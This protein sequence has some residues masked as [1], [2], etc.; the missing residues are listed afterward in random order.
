[1]QQVTLE[2]KLNKKRRLYAI[3]WGLPALLVFLLA[4]NFLPV[5]PIK[6]KGFFKNDRP[7]VIAH[8]GGELLAPS[9]TIAAFTSAATMG[10]DALETDLHIT[11][12]GYL[13]AIHDP[14]VDRTT[15][16]H[17]K[18][19]DMT[20]EEIQKL[21]AGY[22]FKDLDGQYSYR[23]KGVYIPTAEEMFQT[24]GNMRIEME[25]KD[26]NPPDRIDKMASKL[27]ALIEKYHMEDKI[28]VAS[29]DQE[30]LNTFEKYAKGRV[31]TSAGRQEV[32]SFVIFHK[33][34]LRNLFQPHVDAFQLP[35]AD[36]G[37]DLTDKKLI[38]GAHRLGMQMHYWTID[39]PKEMKRLIDAGADGILTNRPDLLLKLLNEK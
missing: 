30:I 7:M 11:K 1:M 37:F 4:V 23:G 38:N 15:N 3:R 10:V 17:G 32:K 25:I 21:D 12:D 27:W 35:T 5:S 20:L 13:V 9:N 2:K 31:A 39:D 14:T 34:F 6:E 19:S 33:F 16:G 29:F 24:F 26:D 36:S 28:L 22:Q 18:V 8:Q